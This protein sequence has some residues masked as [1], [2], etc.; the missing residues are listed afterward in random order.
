MN[1]HFEFL[2][3][4]F[5]HSLQ[6]I[7]LESLNLNLLQLE[8]TLSA[9]QCYRTKQY[10]TPKRLLIQE[11]ATKS[12]R[13]PDC[14]PTRLTM[15]V[16]RLDPPSKEIKM[17]IKEELKPINTNVKLKVGPGVQ[18]I[19]QGNRKLTKITLICHFDIDRLRL[20]F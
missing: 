8:Y 3:T 15:R 9:Y 17:E 7:D 14:P 13:E 2:L 19:Q 4:D 10:Q 20:C 11:I 5:F 6:H 1:I 12:I 18:L 16:R